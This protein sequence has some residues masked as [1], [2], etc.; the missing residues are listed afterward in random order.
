MN[1]IFMMILGAW[2]LMGPL[3]FVVWGTEFDGFF[4]SNKKQVIFVSLLC[5]PIAFILLMTFYVLNF[6]FNFLQLI[7]YKLG[8]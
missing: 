1:E 6:I 8:E 7:Y 4:V 2:A 5:G 3:Y